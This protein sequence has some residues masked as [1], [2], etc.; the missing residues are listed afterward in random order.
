[1]YSINGVTSKNESYSFISPTFLLVI[2]SCFQLEN[3]VD[4]FSTV[5]AS[6]FNEASLK[7]LSF[8]DLIAVVLLSN[9]DII[10][11]IMCSYNLLIESGQ[12]RSSLVIDQ[13]MVLQKML[14]LDRA[15]FL[16]VARIINGKFY[17]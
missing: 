3:L 17:F 13:K 1:M 5:K 14:R 8:N 6:V 15:L 2:F 4:Y 16:E 10:Y 11:T 9:L 12:Y 7:S